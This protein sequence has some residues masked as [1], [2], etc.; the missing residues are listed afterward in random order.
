M[1]ITDWC[2]ML[3]VSPL[4]MQNA[5]PSVRAAYSTASPMASD[6][7]LPTWRP[8]RATSVCSLGLAITLAPSSRISAPR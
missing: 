8:E 7:L 2:R 1:P 5:A 4:P 6:R 3:Y